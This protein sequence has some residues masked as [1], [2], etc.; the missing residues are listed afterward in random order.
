E[1]IL[2]TLFPRCGGR[3]PDELSRDDLREVGR[4]LARIHNV[5][6][7]CE[8]KYRPAI[9]PATYGRD[10]L[11]L[12]QKSTVLPPGTAERLVDAVGKVVVRAEALFAGTALQPI[13]GD[14]HRG[15]LLRGREGFFFLDFDDM[16][17]GPPVQDLWL[18]LPGRRADSAQEIESFLEGYEVFRAFER[19]SLRLIEPLRALRYVRYAAWIASRWQDASFPRA[20]PDWGSERYWQTLVTDLYE[21]VQ[22]MSEED[23]GL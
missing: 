17:I 8:A 13:H 6:S 3:C 21:Q 20:F 7:K 11:A 9:S 18:L 15:N 10:A 16:G 5:A 14:C 22:V 4:L 12:L 23:D 1:G 2:F 19:R